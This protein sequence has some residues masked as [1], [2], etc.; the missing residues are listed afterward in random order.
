[1]NNSC[2]EIAPPQVNRLI[3]NLHNTN[4][5]VQQDSL[6][7]EEENDYIFKS[8]KKKWKYPAKSNIDRSKTLNKDGWNDKG[9]ITTSSAFKEKYEAAKNRIVELCKNADDEYAP[10]QTAEKHALYILGLLRNN[11]VAPSLINSTDDK[12]LIFEFFVDDKFYLIEFY[13]S[14][15]VIYLRRIEGQ[16]K[17]IT[18][19]N[20]SEIEEIIKEITCAY[21]R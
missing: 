12:S 13:N 7:V 20:I 18:E 16:P 17:L 8:K 15:E 3:A 2:H 11:K 4:W 1:M 21:T 14:G 5:K 6:P 9:I 19:T 10:N